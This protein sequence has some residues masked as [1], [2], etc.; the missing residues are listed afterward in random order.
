MKNETIKSTGCC[1][2]F[3]PEPWDGKEITWEDKIFVKDR[4]TS[5]LHMPLNMGKKIVKNMKLIERA[6]VKAEYQLMLFDEKSLWGSDIYIDVAKD[7]PGAQM[8][9]LS[10]TFLT[11]V[12]EGPYQ[13][14]GK[15]AKEMVEYVKSK[16]KEIKKMYFSYTTCPRCAKAYGKNYVIIFAQV[17]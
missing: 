4:V 7:V 2:P 12:F 17:D 16:G 8:A 1:E 6:G 11:K 10:G 13:N 9:T 3:N 5:F 15:W 14:A